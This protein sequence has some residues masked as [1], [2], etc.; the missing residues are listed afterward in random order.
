MS[1]CDYRTLFDK[2]ITTVHRCGCYSM[3]DYVFVSIAQ[4][5]NQNKI[6]NHDIQPHS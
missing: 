4:I 3:F 2:E 6:E 5:D 1:D